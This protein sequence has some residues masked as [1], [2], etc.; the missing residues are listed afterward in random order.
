MDLINDKRMVQQFLDLVAIDSPSFN[1]RSMADYLTEKLTELGFDTIEDDWGQKHGGTCG[2]L[3]G[4]LQGTL[5]CEPLLF[6]CHMDTVGPALGKKAIVQSDGHIISE[7]NTVLGADDLAGV[8]AILEALSVIKE[9]SLDHGPIEVLF[10]VAEEVYCQGAAHYGYNR[11]L[12]KYAYVLDLTGPVGLA[13]NKAPSILT[14]SIEVNGK[15]AHAG[16]APEEGIHAIMVCAKAISQLKLGHYDQDTTLN[17]GTIKGGSADNIVPASCRVS[18]EI[19]SYQHDQALNLIQRIEAIFQ[20]SCNI[21]G[22][23]YEIDYKT[24]FVAYDVSKDSTV[25]ENFVSACNK[26]GLTPILSPTFGG[27]DNHHFVASGISGLVIASAMY[28]CH[29]TEEYTT[30]EDLKKLSHLTLE[31][32]KKRA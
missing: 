26:V 9:N 16:F 27:S 5:E 23:S 31:L 18:G 30:I 11:I 22:A 1:E 14:F 10:T 21:Y 28:A 2:N 25:V 4:Y 7:G 17:I 8:T 3:Y 24:P 32:M 15:P 12:S 13:A 6:S 19:R 20:E 29:S